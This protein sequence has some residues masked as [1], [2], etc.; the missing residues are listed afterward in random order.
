[1][2]H[3]G[4]KTT[5]YMILATATIRKGYNLIITLEI[6]WQNY[7]LDINMCG[8]LVF[9]HVEFVIGLSCVLYQINGKNVTIPPKTIKT[10]FM[11]TDLFVLSFLLFI[12]KN[13]RTERILPYYKSDKLM[14]STC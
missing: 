5:C 6:I 7:L 9:K 1:M 10:T 8:K 13:K 12:L 4:A 11:Y 14:Q 2:A 3:K